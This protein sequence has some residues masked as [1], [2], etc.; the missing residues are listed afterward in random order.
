[1]NTNNGGV[2]NI[3]VLSV[4][5]LYIN[6][7]PARA[8]VE[9]IIGAGLNPEELTELKYLSDRINISNLYG[10][11][12]VNDA[13]RNAT[14]KTLLD[15]TVTTVTN[16]AAITTAHAVTLATHTTTLDNHAIA[17]ASVTSV[18]GGNAAAITGL[19][20]TVT[21]QGVTIAT[22]TGQLAGHD[23]AIGNA[24]ANIVTQTQQQSQ[25]QEYQ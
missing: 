22:H 21:A 16:Q 6:G 19:T 18:S 13:N 14:L 9:D 2:S 8:F 15:S 25:Q 20:S 11:W 17:I 5:A 23:A 12:I 4:G 1:M 7:R 10:N 3:D 24:N